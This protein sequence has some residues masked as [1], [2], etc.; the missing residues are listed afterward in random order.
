M[1][2]NAKR[3]DAAL[4]SGL[5]MGKNKVRGT[6]LRTRPDFLLDI[7]RDGGTPKTSH[8]VTNRHDSGQATIDAHFRD[9]YAVARLRETFHRVT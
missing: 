3:P 8:Q 7:K 6:S 5:R 4:A 1:G 2:L 9:R